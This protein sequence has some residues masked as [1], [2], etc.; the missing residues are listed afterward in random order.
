[1]IPYY[2]LIG[3]PMFLSLIKYD[4]NRRI[5]NK[6]FP[7]FAFFVFFIL[8]L[9]LRSVWCGTDLLNY[10]NKFWLA[11]S[12]SFF[13]LFDL[14][15]VEPGYELLASIIKA[16]S[17]NFQFFLI[18]CALLSVVP[19]MLLYIKESDHCL[20]TVALFVGIAPFS[21]YFSG[22]RQSIAMGV[23]VICY[24]FCKEKKWLLFLIMV[25]LAFL[26]HQSAI[27]LL[28]MYPM[29]H[30]RI[31]K[32]WII[33][34]VV[35]YMVCLLYNKQLFGALLG[36]NQKYE[37]RY[38]ISDTG[39]YTYLILLLI[40]TAYSFVLLKE[41][42][43]GVIGLRNLLVVSLF[44]QCFAPVNIVAMRLNYYY[45]IFIPI[46]IPKIIDNCKTRYIQVARVSSVV[47]VCFFILWFFKEAYFGSDILNIFPYLPFWVD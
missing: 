47:F 2:L 35:I 17:G 30:A 32:D 9:S 15:N 19:L 40:L 10:R 37:S 13:S 44:L 25:F 28:L 29:M 34:I 42:A 7:L 4:D 16:I 12:V 1:M 46:L 31:T 27:I 33:P 45:L 5:L 24:W 38:V 22:L 43:D 6:K 41:D 3:L 39:S 11:E 36:L 26:F 21:L 8:L 14:S 18:V 20:I 23:G